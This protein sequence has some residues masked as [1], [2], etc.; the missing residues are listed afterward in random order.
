M[1][2]LKGIF[3]KPGINGLGV[4]DHPL[5]LP[6]R[7][8]FDDAARHHDYN[9]DLGG[10]AASRAS[11]DKIFFHEMRLRCSSLWQD[12]AAWA[13]YKAVRAFGWLFYHYNGEEGGAR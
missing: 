11:A 5:P 2:A 10:D 9:Y 3:W 13:Y 7:V 1:K 8:R 12:V 6:Y 4:G